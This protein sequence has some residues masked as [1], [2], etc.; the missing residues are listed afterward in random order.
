MYAKTLASVA[1]LGITVAAVPPN[2]AWAAA[3]V[4]PSLAPHDH[5]TMEE[6]LILEGDIASGDLRLV[7]GDYHVVAPNHRHAIATTRTGALMYIR[8]EIRDAA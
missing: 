5:A 8:G 2:Q 4:M 1:V 6:C 3:T 7:A